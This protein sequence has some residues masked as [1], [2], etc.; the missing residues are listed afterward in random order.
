MKRLTNGIK[1]WIAGSTLVG[2][3][4]G[5]SVLAHSGGTVVDTTSLVPASQVTVSTQTTTQIPAL[6]TSA[7]DTVSSAN[8][9]QSLQQLSAPAVVA[10][11]APRLRTSGS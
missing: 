6:D 1:V 5:W 2:F 8:Q 11:N 3:L 9:S 7:A 4:T 10:R